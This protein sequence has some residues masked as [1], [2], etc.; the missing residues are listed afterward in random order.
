MLCFGRGKMEYDLRSGRLCVAEGGGATCRAGR[1]DGRSV[2]VW[3]LSDDVRRSEGL[4]YLCDLQPLR[5]HSVSGIPDSSKQTGP[6]QHPPPVSRLEAA[7]YRSLL[8][9]CSALLLRP[10]GPNRSRPLSF[11]L[12]LLLL[13][14]LSVWGRTPIFE[15]ALGDK[16]GGGLNHRPIENCVADGREAETKGAE[17][18]EEEKK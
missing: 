8:F 2:A 4:I 3:V 12:L 5:T 15:P 17:K 6:L 10:Q 18:K 7:H 9:S 1:T 16:A 13:L 11:L 14:L